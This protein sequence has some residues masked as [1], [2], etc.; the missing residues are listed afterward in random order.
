MPGKQ[1]EHV[2]E[3]RDAGIDRGNAGAIKVN[4]KLDRRL[5]GF[6]A[7]LGTAGWGHNF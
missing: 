7:A 3:K 6:A 1:G 5:G 2:I 4:A